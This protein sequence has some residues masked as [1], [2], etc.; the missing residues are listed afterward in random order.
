LPRRWGAG[1][2]PALI[3]GIFAARART[4]EG[5]LQVELAQL[6]PAPAACRCGAALAAG[7]RIGTTAWRNEAGN[8]PA[9]HRD[10]DPRDLRRHRAGQATPISAAI[11]GG[12]PQCQRWRSS[13][14]NAGKTTLFNRLMKSDAT[15]HAIRHLDPLLRQVRLPD[16]RE[17][18][19]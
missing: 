16:S 5:K 14:T 12:R 18:L 3:L 19:V 4:R 15:V 6:K 11:A 17:L 2:R 9:T 8:R 10:A 1:P 7:R 13:N